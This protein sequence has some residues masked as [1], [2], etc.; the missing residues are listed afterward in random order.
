MTDRHAAAMTRLR[1]F[2]G[3]TLATPNEGEMAEASGVDVNDAAALADAGRALRDEVGLDAL[4]ITRG[5]H[6]M[7]LIDGAD[8]HDIPIVGT[9]DVA[10][11][12]GAGDTVAAATMLGR[13][14]VAPGW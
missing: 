13:V 11:V 5:N 4:L 1:D 6:G 14:A 2:H 7:M 8:A 9:S 10:D 3:A 12:T